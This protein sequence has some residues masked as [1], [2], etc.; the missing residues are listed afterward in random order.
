MSKI[1]WTDKVWNPVTG[2]DAVSPGCDNCYAKVMAETR[3]HKMPSSAHKY[4]NKFKVTCH[5]NELDKP[6]KWTKPCRVFINSMSDLF[7]HNV[8]IEFIVSVYRSMIRNN[9]HTYQVLT[10]RPER[11]LKYYQMLGSTFHDED[12]KHLWLGVSAEN[13]KY[14]D[15]RIPQLLQIPAAKRFV[16]CEPLLGE[17]RLLDHLMSGESPSKCGNCGG[18]HGFMRCPNYG[19]ISK[20]HSEN[21]CTEFK[22]VNHEIDWVIIGCESGPNRRPC[23]LDWVYSL[24]DQC[25]NASVPVFVKQLDI[26][27]KVIK[28]V[29]QF[30]KDLQIQEFPS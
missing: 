2:C 9:Q 3:L 20:T 13:Q 10:K 30:P 17:I 7:H 21:N 24:V 16:S 14:A 11:A 29:E 28:K 1:E 18:W 25:Q 12:F 5:Q 22:R 23:N 4:R 26:D 6:S 8:P 19:G 27:G 15:K